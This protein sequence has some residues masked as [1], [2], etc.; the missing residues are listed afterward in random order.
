MFYYEI[1]RFYQDFKDEN[2]FFL[3]VLSSRC[4]NTGSVTKNHVKFSQMR[5]KT[6]LQL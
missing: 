6:P 2:L 4:K 5:N 1:P 3:S